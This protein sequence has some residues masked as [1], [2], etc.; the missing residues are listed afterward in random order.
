[1]ATKKK[2]FESRF[3]EPTKKAIEHYIEH[4]V[5]TEKPNYD[6]NLEITADSIPDWIRKHLDD[7]SARATLKE[8]RKPDIIGVLYPK[9]KPQNPIMNC[10]S[11]LIVVEVK[12]T[13][14]T[15]E[16][17]YQAKMYDELYNA[18]ETY[19]VSPDPVPADILWVLRN[20]P[21]IVSTKAGYGRVKIRSLYKR[22]DGVYSLANSVDD[23]ST[24]YE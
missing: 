6:Y 13:N 5:R 16:D 3:Y 11:E 19:L 8:K 17:I 23:Y 22:Q 2:E 15:F 1:M 10:F 12:P 7:V 24:Q 4:Y 18:K 20:R 14:I 9:D 21:H